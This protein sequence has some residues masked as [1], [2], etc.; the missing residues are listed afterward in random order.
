L[1]LT[2]TLAVS[3]SEEPGNFLSESGF[4]RRD[5]GEANLAGGVIAGGDFDAV[6]K[7]CNLAVE[8][9][10]I[11]SDTWMAVPRGMSV[12]DGIEEVLHELQI[13]AAFPPGKRP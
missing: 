3:D 13:F 1:R 2:L 10:L 11:F 6:E 7:S 12:A 5:R 4:S 8:I 9:E